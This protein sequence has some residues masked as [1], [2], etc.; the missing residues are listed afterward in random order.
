M[1]EVDEVTSPLTAAIAR[2]RNLVHSKPT[3]IL[4]C[5]RQPTGFF[6][7]RT[8]RDAESIT[9]VAVR[10]VFRTTDKKQ[11]GTDRANQPCDL[12][13]EMFSPRVRHNVAIGVMVL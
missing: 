10:E 3:R 13:D 1:S 8:T 7:R 11:M 9:E 12:L 5:P 2:A 6:Y 4:D